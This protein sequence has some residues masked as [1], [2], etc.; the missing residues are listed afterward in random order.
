MKTH[1]VQACPYAQKLHDPWRKMQL[2]P[3]ELLAMLETLV[4]TTDRT[5]SGVA[6]NHNN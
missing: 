6:R 3:G 2:Q 4:N 1:C 5:Q